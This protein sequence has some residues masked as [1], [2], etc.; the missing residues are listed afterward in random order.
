MKIKNNSINKKMKKIMNENGLNSKEYEEIER[1][2]N[3][4]ELASKYFKLI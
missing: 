3:L 1:K 4:L 2:K